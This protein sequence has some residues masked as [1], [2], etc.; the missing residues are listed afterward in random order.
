MADISAIFGTL[1]ALG[2]VFPGMITSWWLLFPATV[3]RARLR[4]DRTPWLCFFA[5][6]VMT[7]LIAVPTVVLLALPLAPAKFVGWSIVF[8]T[9]TFATLGAAGIAATMGE[10]LARRS[11]GSLSPAASFVR[12]A[13]ALELAAMF[14]FIGWLVVI[15]LTIVVA[16]GATAFALLRWL[17]AARVKLPTASEAVAHG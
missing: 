2:I 5:G 4:L 17:P 1:L 6:G 8:L 12:G 7:A 11:N 3:E 9:L 10:R 16:L 15:P 14:P 13:V